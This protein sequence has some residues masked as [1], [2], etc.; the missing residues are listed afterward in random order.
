MALGGSGS[1]WWTGKP[2]M[3]Q[4]MVSQRVGHNWATELNWLSNLPASFVQQLLE[5]PSHIYTEKFNEIIRRYLQSTT[6]HS[7]STHKTVTTRVSVHSWIIKTAAAAAAAAAKSRQSCPTLCDP[8]DGSPPGS[9]IPG[10]LQA[11]IL[12]W[13]AISFSNAWNWKVKVKS[14][15]CAWLFTTPWTVAYQAPQSTGYSRQEYWSGLPLPSPKEG[16]VPKNWCFWTVVLEKTLESPLGG[17]EIKPVNPKGNQPSIFSGR[18]H[19]E[20]PILWP[21]DGKSWLNGK[22]PDA[23]KIEG[24]RRSG[25]QKIR[26]LGSITDSMDM[27]LNK[28][29]EIEKDTGA[30]RAAVHGVAKSWTRLSAWKTAARVTVA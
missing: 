11:R 16:W 9:A 17:K 12:K 15:S 10:I 3:L 23:G 25:G 19:A 29:Q 26:W 2:G 27:S 5:H 18:T 30:W 21:P 6:Q 22:D 7:K 24:R 20:A 8:I 28:L 1:W 14:I 13:V 4:F